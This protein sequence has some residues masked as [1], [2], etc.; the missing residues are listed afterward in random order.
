MSEAYIV[1]AVRT[2]VGRRKGSLAGVHSADLG[3]VPLNALMER[4]G[5]DP[6]AVEDVIYGCCDTVGS[7]AGDIART[8]WL[9]AGLPQH[10]PGTTIDRQ[11]G[12]SQQAV[13]FCRPGR[14]ERH[15]GSGRRRRGAEYDPD[16][17]QLR[18]AGGPAPGHGRSFHRLARLG[19][20]LRA[21]PAVAVSLRPA[22]CGKVGH[23]PRR[24]GSLCAGKP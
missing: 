8:C 5:V 3:A 1:D 4:T 21:G 13:H 19:Q 24:D 7:Q 17:D 23:L 12:S 16:P 20:A 18:H 2:P 9:V 15:P 10:V 22:H 14:D 11:C 6:A